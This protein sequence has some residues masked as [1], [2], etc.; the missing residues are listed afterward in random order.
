MMV[1]LFAQIGVG[2]WFRYLTGG[3]EGLGA[4]ALLVPALAELG[5][6]L[7]VL[8][9]I[10]AVGT[11]LVVIGGSPVPAGMPPGLARIPGRGRGGPST[12]GLRVGRVH[13]T[14]E[15]QDP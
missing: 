14:D 1:Q 9:M 6:L 5:A 12:S 15:R 10:G 3:L 7:L 13:G 2:Q 4:V 11:H 8:V